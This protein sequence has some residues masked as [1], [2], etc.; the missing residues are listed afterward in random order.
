MN[1]NVEPIFAY[2]WQL[3]N[4]TQA[5]PPPI[6]P[7]EIERGIHDQPTT[8]SKAQ[9]AKGSCPGGERY[10]KINEERGSQTGHCL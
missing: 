6:A 7:K 4:L 1:L 3:N 8:S 5:R 2:D 9:M 10:T